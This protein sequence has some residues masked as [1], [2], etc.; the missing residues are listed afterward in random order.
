MIK[1][2]IAERNYTEIMDVLSAQGCCGGK[3]KVKPSHPGE[4]LRG[5]QGANLLPT[6]VEYMTSGP[7]VALH[8]RRE[9]AIGH[10]HLIGPTNFDKAKNERLDSPEPPAQTAQG[11]RATAAIAQA[12]PVENWASS[13]ASVPALQTYFCRISWQPLSPAALLRKWPPALCPR[14]PPKRY[15][16]QVRAPPQINKADIALM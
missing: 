15:A 8:L 13:S 7:V 16:G 12:A 10:R 11:T 4:L 5:A 9:F 6:L 3:T 14:L 1:P 2:L